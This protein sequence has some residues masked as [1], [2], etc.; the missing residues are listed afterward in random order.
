MSGVDIVSSLVR[1]F[2]KSVDQLAL[3]PTPSKPTVPVVPKVE[4]TDNIVSATARARKFESELRAAQASGNEDESVRL[5]SEFSKDKEAVSAL[6]K[7]KDVRQQSLQ[8]EAGKAATERASRDAWIS[9]FSIIGQL[10]SKKYVS[11]RTISATVAALFGQGATVVNPYESALGLLSTDPVAA[12]APQAQ[13]ANPGGSGALPA[14]AQPSHPGNGSQERNPDDVDP[15]TIAQ[16]TASLPQ[17]QHTALIRRPAA[18]RHSSL[19]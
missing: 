9:L 15:E 13:Q 12:T 11:A 16:G 10:G 7:M 14:A 8:T 17:I 18:T 19:S 3:N 4:T 6:R 2:I 1:G 5:I